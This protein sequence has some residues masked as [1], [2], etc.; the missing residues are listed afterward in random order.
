M[1]VEKSRQW[2]FWARGSRRR[3]GRPFDGVYMAYERSPVLAKLFCTV[4][5]LPPEVEPFSFITADGLATLAR[6]LEVGTGGV[7][8]DVGCGRGGPG[9]WVARATGVSYVGI[10]ASPVAVEQAGRR[11]EVFGLDGRARFAVG[12]LDA[13]GL[14]DAGVDAV[15]C[16]DAFQFA[17]DRVAAGRE[18]RRVLRPGGRLALTGWE[19]RRRDDP[20]LPERFRGLWFAD[21]LSE[22]GF[23]DVEVTERPDWHDRYRAV[24]EAVLRLEPGDDD[25]V[26][27]LAREARS[28]LPLVGRKRR[29]LVTA[30]R[31]T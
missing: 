18:L 21:I 10:D 13:T 20:V 7:L 25:A 26:R 12:S 8:V 6:V 11:V 31:P 14:D 30:R 22:A 16:V 2:R 17:R 3:G 4:L 15:M 9:M 1:T 28:N 29:V 19:P 24:Y 23:V 27:G 5:D